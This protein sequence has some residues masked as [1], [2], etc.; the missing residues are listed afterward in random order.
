MKEATGVKGGTVRMNDAYVGNNWAKMPT[1][2]LECG[3]LSTPANDWILTTDDYQEKI[4][5]GITDGLVAVVE[6]KLDK[7]KPLE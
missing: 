7:Y 3:F 2:L 4:A 1:F 5:R 6:G